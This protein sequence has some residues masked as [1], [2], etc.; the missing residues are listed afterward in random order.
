MRDSGSRTNDV[1]RGSV[2]KPNDCPCLVMAAVSPCALLSHLITLSP[3]QE[4][5][6]RQQ[7]EFLWAALY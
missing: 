2:E 4:G 6:E 7:G 5:A 1:Q 3:P